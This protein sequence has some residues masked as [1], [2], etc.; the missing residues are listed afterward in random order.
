MIFPTLMS[1]LEG[2]SLSSSA[3]PPP[4]APFTAASDHINTARIIPSVSEITMVEDAWTHSFLKGRQSLWV[5]G[6]QETQT[7]SWLGPATGL[8]LSPLRPSGLLGG[9]SDKFEHWWQLGI[10]LGV[11]Q[12]ASVALLYL[13]GKVLLHFFKLSVSFVAAPLGISFNV[14]L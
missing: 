11:A 14:K 1:S 10:H 12:Q 3:P 8:M 9:W 2:T 6:A 7:S 4:L 13:I 5:Y